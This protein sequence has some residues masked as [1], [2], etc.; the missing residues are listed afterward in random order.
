MANLTPA[1]INHA[2]TSDDKL[3]AL[4]V[5]WVTELESKIKELEARIAELEAP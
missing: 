4:W 5:R 1:P 2:A 3:T